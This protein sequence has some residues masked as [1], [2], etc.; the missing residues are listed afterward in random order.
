MKHLLPILCLFVFSCDELDSLLGN[1]DE[2]ANPLVRGYVY[3]NS[4]S[5]IENTY[6][7]LGYEIL[8]RPSMTIEFELNETTNV[9]IWLENECNEIVSTA[10]NNQY[11]NPG[12][13]T[14]TLDA[15]NSDGLIIPDGRYQVYYEFNY[16][17]LHIQN[18]ELIVHPPPN[19]TSDGYVRCIDE[20]GELICEYLALTDSNGYFEFSQDC[21]SLGHIWQGT[22][23]FGNPVGMYSFNRI[24]LFADDVQ[25]YGISNYFE[26]DSLNGAETTIII[27]R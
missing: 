26:V 16:E 11:Y 1:D 6:I 5:P 18:V 17:I 14:V 20:N 10:I 22:D 2:P 27:N 25:N 8:N 4:G 21:L 24:R 19:S 3:D 9:N 12:S 23:E 15:L 13:H 7:F